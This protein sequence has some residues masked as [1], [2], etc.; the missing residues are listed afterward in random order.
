MIDFVRLDQYHATAVLTAEPLLMR[1]ADLEGLITR[2]MQANIREE[3]V[4]NEL[5][6]TICSLESSLR[7]YDGSLAAVLECI[8]QRADEVCKHDRKTIDDIYNIVQRLHTKRSNS[9]RWKAG[10]DEHTRPTEESDSDCGSNGGFDTATV[11]ITVNDVVNEQNE[12][13]EISNEFK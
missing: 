7:G 4:S 10:V 8:S 12:A 1:A 6:K 9:N 2:A 3:G 5:R 13:P 11:N